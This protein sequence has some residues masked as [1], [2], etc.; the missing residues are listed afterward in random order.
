MNNKVSPK[1]IYVA[2]WGYEANFAD[3]YEVVSVT[4][5]GKSA[6]L[7]HLGNKKTSPATSCMDYGSS[8]ADTSVTGREGITTRRIHDNGSYGISFKVGNYKTAFKWNGDPIEE[9]NHH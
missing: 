6:K 5:S 7:R 9:Y 8:V 2:T 4:K 1:D 3:F